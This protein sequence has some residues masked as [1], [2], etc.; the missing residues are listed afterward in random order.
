[1]DPI[2]YKVDVQ[3]PFTAAVQGYQ[4]GSAIRADQAQQQQQ[5]AA[6]QQQQVQ[7]QR[8]QQMRT[9]LSALVNNPNA[10]AR[11]YAGMALKYPELKDQFKNSWDMVSKDQQAGRLDTMTRAYSALTTGR[12]DIA[13]QIMRDRATAMQ[14]SGAP[15]ADVKAQE[16]WADLIK[17]SPEQARHI[18]GLLLSSVMD[19]DKFAETF[20]KLGGER[21]ADELQPAA[22]TK[23]NAD[24]ET[25]KV[26]ARFA[27]DK[28]VTE[29]NLGKAQIQHL[30]ADTEIAR[31]NSR[32]AAMN[33]AT[34]REGND[35]KR[36]ELALKLDEAVRERD[37]KI[38]GKVADAESAAANIDNTLNTIERIKKNP[39]LDDVLGSLEGRMP[40]LT[41]DESADAIALIETLGS[42]AFLSQI[43][44]MKGQGALSNAEGEKLQSALTNLK[45]TQSEKQFRENLDE[46]SRL[47]KKARENIA[48]RSGVPLGR[49][50][51]P[52][53]PGARPPIDS[54][55]KG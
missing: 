44:S 50:D 7:L 24:A 35:L 28:V 3:T 8:Q 9:D 11:D 10:G 33:A 25:A 5:Q 21:R 52:A 16:M 1:M 39:R 29:L 51:T 17:Q 14:N 15:E 37:D 32:I 2:N 49:P 42:Q 36:K 53:A 46:A 43:P 4:V 31:M 41:S 27:M 45:R 18:G 55:F 40:A 19:P 54:F 34:S 26:T 20:A 12:S 22:V 30:N 6:L 13:E 48:K 23:A 47:M 38:R